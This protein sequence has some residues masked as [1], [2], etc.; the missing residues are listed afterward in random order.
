MPR[1]PLI[2]L[3]RRRAWAGW[4]DVFV[5]FIVGVIVSIASGNA[6]IGNWTTDDNGFVTQHSG[7]SVNLTGGP[8]LLW[9]AI[10]LLYHFIAELETGQTIGKR[11]MGLKV[12][13]VNGRPLGV[14]PVLLRTPRPDCR[15]AAVFLPRRLDRHARTASAAAATRRPP[16]RH[17]GGARL[18]SLSKPP[19]HDRTR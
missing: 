6:H 14:R 2:D 17:N 15:R 18:P 1:D 8:F 5:L 16:R 12:I 4:I 19:I 11:I 10:A 9:V 13:T 7:L 3:L